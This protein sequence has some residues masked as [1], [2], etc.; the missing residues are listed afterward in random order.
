MHLKCLKQDF[1]SLMEEDYHVRGSVDIIKKDL[2]LCE[3]MA[4]TPLVLGKAAKEIF[5][6]TS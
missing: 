3:E 1:L 6:N 5:E 2:S 4:D